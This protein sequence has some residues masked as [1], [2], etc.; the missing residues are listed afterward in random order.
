VSKFNCNYLVIG[1]YNK[2]VTLQMCLILSII[3]RRSSLI[4]L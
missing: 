1:D 2:F 3:A 4:A